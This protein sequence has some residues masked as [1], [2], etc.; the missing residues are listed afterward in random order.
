ML[1]D[2]SKA[3]KAKTWYL[4][5]LEL[6]HTEKPYMITFD[7]SAFAGSKTNHEYSEYEAVMCDVH[8]SKTAFD[9][10]THGFQFR[11]WQT[12][13]LSEEFAD[14]DAIRESIIPRSYRTC[15]RLSPTRSRFM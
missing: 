13:L 7:S 9:I 3:F 2:E 11:D 4:K 15:L 12:G 14:E 8:T 10:N 5:R 1:S 6:Y